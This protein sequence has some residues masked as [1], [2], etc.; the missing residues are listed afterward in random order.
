MTLLEEPTETVESPA[1]KWVP[2]CPVSRLLTNRG[3]SALIDGCPV[4]LFRL[5]DDSLHAIS[6]SDPFSGATVMSRGLVGSIGGRPVVVSPMFKQR[7][8]IESGV[9]LEDPSVSVAVFAVRLVDGVIE[10]CL[11]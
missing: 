10:V 11:T 1:L 6:G 3:I 9:C 2:V 7:F 4:A 5:D 8:D